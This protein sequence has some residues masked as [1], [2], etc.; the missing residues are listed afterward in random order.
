MH[1]VGLTKSFETVL[2]EMEKCANRLSPQRDLRRGAASD[3]DP[4]PPTN[5]ERGSLSSSITAACPA[6]HWRPSPFARVPVPSIPTPQLRVS[7]RCKA[8]YW[9]YVLSRSFQD[10]R[11]GPSSEGAG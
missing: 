3:I 1:V 7:V 11:L 4:C 8:L 2:T 9:A 6:G 5:S 10:A